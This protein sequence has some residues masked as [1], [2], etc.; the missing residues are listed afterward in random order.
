MVTVNHPAFPVPDN[1]KIKIWRYMDF[2]KFVSM[3]DHQGVFFPRASKLGDPFEGSYSRG[4]EAL[5]PTLYKNAPNIASAFQRMSPF[6]RWARDWTMISCWHM[7][8][9]ESAGMWKLYAKTS[10]AIA[11]QSTYELLRES[12]HQSLQIGVITYIDYE[13]E[14]MPENNT[15]YPYMHKRK[16]FEHE[17]ELRAISQDLPQK[18]SEADIKATPPADGVWESVD[19]SKLVERIFVAPTSPPWFQELVQNVAHNYR[20][21]KPVIRSSLEN[22]P[23]F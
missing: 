5:R 13:K 14:W 17:R 15:F 11:I 10:E 12:L 16:S 3:L 19:L 21:D 6:M 8:E 4:N 9:H 7:N 23:F 20:L 18:G 22:E 2:T 1:P